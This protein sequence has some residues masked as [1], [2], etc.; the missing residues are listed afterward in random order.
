MASWRVV[1]EFSNI[2]NNQINKFH[3]YIVSA[4]P[5]NDFH[6]YDS[7]FI[8]L[9]RWVLWR[10]GCWGGRAQSLLAI[11][12]WAGA[13]AELRVGGGAGVQ[14]T[15]PLQGKYTKRIKHISKTYKRIMRSLKMQRNTKVMWF[16]KFERF[17]EQRRFSDFK[18]SMSMIF[19][20]GNAA[21]WIDP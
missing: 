21:S 7:Q 8:R 18:L 5:H 2:V 17:P 19:L 4:D 6:F 10:D 11:S 14:G 9:E 15:Q 13:P 20:A 1:D 12:R 16:V 3:V